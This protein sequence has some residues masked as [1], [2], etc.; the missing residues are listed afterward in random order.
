MKNR[1]YALLTGLFIIALGAAIAGAAIWLNGEQS[2][3]E[4]YRIVT[5]QAVSGLEKNSDVLYFGVPAGKVTG[6]HLDKD[7]ARTVVIDIAVNRSVHITCG[8]YV[9][10]QLQGM[11][12]ASQVALLDTGKSNQS[13]PANSQHPARIPLRPSLLNTLTHSGKHMMAQLDKLGTKLNQFVSKKNSAHIGQLL[14]HAAAATDELTR[15]E[16]HLDRAAVTLPQL[17]RHMQQTLAGIGGLTHHLNSTAISLNRLARHATKLTD[18]G[19]ALG[20]AALSRSLPEL[21]RTLRDLRQTSASVKTLSRN[22][23]RNPQRLLS[24]PDPSSPGPGE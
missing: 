24:G 17:S 8:T 23:N 12:G 1:A 13:L 9:K 11:T 21:N 2:A 15:L 19:Q 6:V 14:A 20:Q 16:R 5:H 22:L 10:M 3:T 7:R 4:P 18:T